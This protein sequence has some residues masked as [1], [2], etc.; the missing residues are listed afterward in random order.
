MTDPRKNF[1]LKDSQGNPHRY[2]V[3]FLQPV[4]ALPLALELLAMGAGP[5]LQFVEKA[6]KVTD[7][8]DAEDLQTII[9]NLDFNAMALDL[10]S[11]LSAIAQKPELIRSVFNGTLRDGKDLGIDMIYNQAFAGNWSEWYQA[12]FSILK[13][14]GFLAFFDSLSTNNEPNEAASTGTSNPS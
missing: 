12:I 2:E 10:K 11:S 8:K 6:V 7:A 5:L 1:T 14:N 4:E 9:A 13:A 3:F